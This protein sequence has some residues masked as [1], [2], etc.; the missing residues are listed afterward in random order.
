ML[1]YAIDQDP[2]PILF[3]E[4][5]ENMAQRLV[6]G[7]LDPII[8]DCEAIRRHKPK[9]KDK[10]KLLEKYFDRCTLTL[11]GAASETSMQSIPIRYLF[12]DEIDNK[13]YQG[14]GDVEPA[15]RACQQRTKSFP[16]NR[17]IILTSTPSHPEGNVWVS[18][19]QG[20][21]EYFH[22]PC[23]HCQWFQKLVFKKPNDEPGGLKFGP[24][25]ILP[26]LKDKDGKWLLD[27]VRE[28]AYYECENCQGHIQ[29]HDKRRILPKGRW[30]PE[31]RRGNHRSFQLSSLY[32]SWTPFGEVAEAF[33]KAKNN[34]GDLR[35]FTTGWLALPWQEAKEATKAEQILAHRMTYEAGTCP[36]VPS[37]VILSA[38]VGLHACHFVVRAWCG[39]SETSYLLDYGEIGNIG[40]IPNWEAFLA[41]QRRTYKCP[42]GEIRINKAVIDSGYGELTTPVYEFCKQNRWTPFKGASKSLEK[43]WTTGKGK[44]GTDII[45]VDTWAYKDHFLYKLAI[46]PG[47]PG[48]WNLHRDVERLYAKHLSSEKIIE[49]TDSYG[50]IKRMWDRSTDNHWFDCEVYSMCAAEASSI[51]HLPAACAEVFKANQPVKPKPQPEAHKPRLLRP[52]GRPYMDLGDRH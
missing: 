8:E 20:S 47:E 18:F 10:F 27:K 9:S 29:N 14:Q 48:S 4:P 15:L 41:V 24:K 26:E 23:P 43:R 13:N 3:V 46:P 49:K 19:L 21:Q 25:D 11:V 42:A 5:T 7:R 12:C 36:E 38:D 31:N 44:D 39:Q 30:V 45:L 37:L 1:G 50:Q 40:E 32:P 6:E 2:G 28:H 33:L 35:S 34:P 16:W 51:K 17:K 22:V 52:D